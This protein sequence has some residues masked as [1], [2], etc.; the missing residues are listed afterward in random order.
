[1]SCETYLL[2]P[3]LVKEASFECK[4]L[5]LIKKMMGSGHPFAYSALCFLLW[6]VFAALP[7]YKIPNFFPILTE[8]VRLDCDIFTNI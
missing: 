1:M 5:N 3:W 2:L 4:K 6:K 7:T 8:K